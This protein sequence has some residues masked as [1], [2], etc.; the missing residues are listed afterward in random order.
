[1]KS[2]STVITANCGIGGNGAARGVAEQPDQ[3]R[4]DRDREQRHEHGARETGKLPEQRAVE[5][6][7]ILS[8][9]NL[10]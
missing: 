10:A 5:D 8:L 2:D 1:M 3:P 6:H 9:W 7:A 4:R